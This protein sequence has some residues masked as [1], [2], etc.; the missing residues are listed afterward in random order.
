MDRKLAELAIKDSTLM[1]LGAI[2]TPFAVAP[3]LGIAGFGVYRAVSNVAAPVRLVLN[4]L[5]PTLAGQALSTH[6]SRKR[7]LSS[8]GLS[9]AFGF[10][11]YVALMVVNAMQLSLGSLTAVVEYAAPAALFVGANFLGHYYYIIARTHT[12]GRLLLVGR[13]VQTCLAVLLPMGGV[14]TLGLP[15][16]ICGYALATTASSLTWLAL[17]VK[18]RAPVTTNDTTISLA[19]R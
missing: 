1:D 5:R 15:G 11:A 8:I 18:A 19:I 4:P 3:L 9:L 2:G 16:A 13:I 7:V 12:R 6:T 17:V 10:A 14:I